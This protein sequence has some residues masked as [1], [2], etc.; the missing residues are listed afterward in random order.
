MARTQLHKVQKRREE[1][2]IPM[3]VELG[4]GPEARILAELSELKGKVDESLAQGRECNTDLK[5]LRKE[6]GIDGPHGRL[7]I[8][9]TAVGRYAGRLEAL[10]TERIEMQA[11]HRLAHSILAFCG[12]GVGGTLIAALGRIFGIR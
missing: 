8:L 9:E 3:E 10:E 4:T 1:R 2:L 11:R 7:P 12:G 6:L 5:L